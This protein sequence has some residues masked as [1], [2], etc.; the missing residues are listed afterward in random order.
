MKKLIA[1]IIVVVSLLFMLPTG[2]VKAASFGVPFGGK[3]RNVIVCTCPA[4]FGLQITVGPPRPGIFMYKPGIS[5]LFSYFNIF[6]PGPYVLGIASGY[7]PCLQY[8][9]TGCIPLSTGGPLIRL[10]G[11]SL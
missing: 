8:T 4:N 9:G 10:V 7:N 1:V 3:I 2:R 11:T 6:R 5:R